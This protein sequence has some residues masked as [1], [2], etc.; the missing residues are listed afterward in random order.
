MLGASGGNVSG[1]SSMA[2]LNYQYKDHL[3]SIRRN[4]IRV[5]EDDFGLLFWFLPFTLL[6]AQK[7][8]TET[9]FL[10]GKR[11]IKDGFSYSFSAGIS[12]IQAR[13]LDANNV[14]VLNT[15]SMVG[16]PVEFNVRWFKSKKSTYKFLGLVP[17][18]KPTGL[19]MST[20]IKIFGTIANEAYVGIGINFGFGYY[21]K[22]IN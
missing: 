15:K 3:F 2:S 8:L 4:S 19:G 14:I 1:F 10:Y 20:G 22:Y 11:Y 5:I 13:K 7:K 21:K 18:G 9:A 6:D 17:I 16:I 12:S